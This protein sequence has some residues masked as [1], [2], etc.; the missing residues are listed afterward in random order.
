MVLQGGLK[1]SDSVEPVPLN[2]KTGTS[3][4]SGNL[5][6]EEDADD[7]WIKLPSW[8]AGV[9]ERQSTTRQGKNSNKKAHA[10][11]TKYVTPEQILQ[12]DRLGGIWQYLTAPDHQSIELGKFVQYSKIA[13]NKIIESSEKEELMRTKFLSIKVDKA[14]KKIVEVFQQEQMDYLTPLVNRAG[15]H[16]SSYVKWFD[17][18]GRT[19]GSPVDELSADLFL[20]KPYKLT[21]L[22]KGKDMRASLKHF[23]ERKQLLE[24]LPLN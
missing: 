8:R 2:L 10:F 3:F 20:L 19:T 12:K 5:N 23:L 4:L 17:E 15:F 7:E 14:N 6:D 16:Q 9:F 1:M 13:D 21:D 18:A 11:K 22:Y 24:L